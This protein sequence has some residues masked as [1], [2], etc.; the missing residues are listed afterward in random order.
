MVR[1]MWRKQK[2]SALLAYRCANLASNQAPSNFYPHPATETRLGEAGLQ[3]SSLF[4][5]IGVLFLNQFTLYFVWHKGTPLSDHTLF[6]A[7]DSCAHHLVFPFFQLHA[8]PSTR[9]FIWIPRRKSDLTSHIR[10][11]CTLGNFQQGQ[12]LSATVN[13]ASVTPE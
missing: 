5:A 12:I 7:C 4:T 10:Y 13:N 2:M 3:H 11:H 8:S 6:C 9:P 1:L